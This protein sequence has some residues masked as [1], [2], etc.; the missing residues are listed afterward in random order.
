MPH[1]EERERVW[2]HARELDKGWGKHPRL[3]L[4]WKKLELEAHGLGWGVG[5]GGERDSS[6]SFP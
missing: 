2:E 4:S 6:S 3:S 5:E 1:L